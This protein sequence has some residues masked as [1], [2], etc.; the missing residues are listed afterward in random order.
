MRPVVLLVAAV[1]AVGAGLFVLKTYGN[2]PQS[3][4]AGTV[5]DV[6]TVDVLVAKTA[7]PVGTILTPDMIE[8]QA[9]P[10][11]LMVEGFVSGS[12]DIAGHVARGEFAA[13]EPFTTAKLANPN[14]PSFLAAALDP[15]MRAVTIATDAIS[16][17]AGYVFAGD[18]VDVM[19]THNI[20]AEEKNREKT[21]TARSGDKPEYVE[22][23]V[24]N[25][26]VLA[27][28]VRPITGKDAQTAAPSSIT[29]E[30]DAIQ[31]QNLRLAEKVGTLSLALRPLKGEEE[32][33]DSRPISAIYLTKASVSTG[34]GEGVRIV[35]GASSTKESQSMQALPGNPD[36][37]NNP[38][39]V[40]N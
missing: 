20:P 6:A 24:A 23:L 5:A 8:H 22:V 27:V 36:I 40:K 13:H 28:N 2:S 3:Q 11:H 38:D 25:A 16:G 26:R 34:G 18:H 29:L 32:N 37:S 9:W 14:D 12:T 39:A 4:T 10:S 30:V 35:R 19:L 7:I 1:V 21:G 15:N 33:A 17:I 31:A